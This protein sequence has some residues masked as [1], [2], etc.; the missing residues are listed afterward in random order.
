M[1]LK[2][3]NQL[4]SVWTS[5][6]SEFSSGVWMSVVAVLIVG[7]MVFQV[8]TNFSP[9]ESLRMTFGEAFMASLS[10]LT[11]Q[12]KIVGTTQVSQN[13]ACHNIFTKRGL[14]QHI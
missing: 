14:P 9:I 1:V 10:G 6:T 3:G 5:Y 2:P 8:V 4:G 7:A 11:A 13:A 12:S